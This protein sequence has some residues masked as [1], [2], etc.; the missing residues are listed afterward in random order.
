[1]TVAEADIK[2]KRTQ[3]NALVV[4]PASASG[5][6]FG[7]RDAMPSWCGIFVFWALNKSGVPMPKWQLGRS[8]MK[9]QAAYPPGYVPHP[10]DI[11][12]RAAYSH[13]AIVESASGNTVRT[14][15]GNT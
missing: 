9:P 5:T 7:S 12:Y 3:D 14:I 1:G 6:K 10:G 13:F 8:P 15:N 4:D 11:A 2:K